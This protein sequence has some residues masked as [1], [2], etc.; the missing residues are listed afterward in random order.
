MTYSQI[1]VCKGNFRWSMGHRLLNYDGPCRFL[2]GHNFEAE[3]EFVANLSDSGTIIESMVVDFSLM[4]EIIQPIIDKWDHCLMLNS[5]D[6]II[7][8]LQSSHAKI[9]T[10]KGNPTAE[11]IAQILAKE[12]DERLILKKIGP[13]VRKIRVTLWE[14]PTNKATV[15]R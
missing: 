2:H 1:S 12:V 11:N 3:V 4:K 8:V 13:K 9:I 7:N 5:E 6:N 14:T 10:V 15:W